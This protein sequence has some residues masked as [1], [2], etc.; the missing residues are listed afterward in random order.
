[1]GN[2]TYVHT[3]KSCHHDNHKQNSK[4]NNC[5]SKLTGVA[6]SE[7]YL[8]RWVCP[9]CNTLNLNDNKYCSGCHRRNPSIQ[10]EEEEEQ[11]NAMI[12]VLVAVAMVGL[13]IYATFFRK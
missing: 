6:G 10:T 7:T 5:A 13:V 12:G 8:I 2:V 1:M 3:C 9:S 4:C 11:Q